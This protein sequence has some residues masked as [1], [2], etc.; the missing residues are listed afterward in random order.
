MSRSF[1]LIAYGVGGL[2]LGILGLFWALKDGIP[3][4][5]MDKAFTLQM[6]W[7][8]ILMIIGGLVAFYTFFFE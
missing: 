4:D 7:G 3:A 6:V 2:I 5:D 8:A 1:E